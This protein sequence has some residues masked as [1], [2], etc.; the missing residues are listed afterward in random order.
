MTFEE[1]MREAA[2]A[3]DR[4]VRLAMKRYA[5]GYVTDE[6]DITT[7]LTGSLDTE[8]SG[9]I[10]GLIW[11]ASSVRHRSGVAAEEARIGADI[12]IHVSLDTP[13]QK[14]SKGVLVQA[15]RVEPSA[16]LSARDKADLDNQ[17][18]RMLAITPASFVFDYAKRGM[19]VGSA[20][21]IRGATE[22][23][24]YRQCSWTPRRFFME[25]FRCPVGDSR[26]SSGH[27]ADLPVPTV[28]EISAVG[29][30]TETPPPDLLPVLG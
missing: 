21:R 28:V 27:V 3:A 23:D 13:T 25:L 20:S 9:Q 10:G 7:R 6:D 8:L 5:Q 16:N 22:R 15:K 14:Y 19:R 17:C 2:S 29:D 30:L 12:L 26:L 11:N 4:A 18:D 1:A 24:L